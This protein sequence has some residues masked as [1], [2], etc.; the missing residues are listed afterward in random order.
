MARLQIDPGQS[1]RFAQLDT[2]Q[3]RAI[4]RAVNRGLAVENRAHADLAIVIGQRQIRFWRWVWVGGPILGAIQAFA[5]EPLV[6]LINGA[7]ATMMLLLMSTLWTRRARRAIVRNQELLDRRSGSSRQRSAQGAGD[8]GPSGSRTPGG[9]HTP[10]GPSRKTDGD[11][12]ATAAEGPP[13]HLPGPR[14]PSP[15]GK[16]RRGR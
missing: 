10:R 2:S 14:P 4:L 3:R 16:K 8:S 1:R 15:R 7:V 6:A 11:D 13:S 5:I 12:G 9:G